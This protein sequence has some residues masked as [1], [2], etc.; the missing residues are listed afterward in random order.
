MAV[1]GAW[2]SLVSCKS[3]KRSLCIWA[4]V[5]GHRSEGHAA[6]SKLVFLK[7]MHLLTAN[8]H[9]S[10]LAG[11]CSC[12]QWTPV[13]DSAQHFADSAQQLLT[14]KDVIAC[15]SGTCCCDRS[16]W[17]PHEELGLIGGGQQRGQAC[18]RVC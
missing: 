9:I 5:S 3:P 1:R 18:L 11:V 13:A 4:L 10:T 7:P 2:T 15:N 8:A 12:G 6:V 17:I 14:M 16:D